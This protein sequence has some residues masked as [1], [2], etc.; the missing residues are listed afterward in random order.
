MISASPIRV[1]AALSGALRAAS[2]GL[3]PLLV[4]AVIVAALSWLAAHLARQHPLHDLPGRYSLVAI[5]AAAA[6]GW[7]SA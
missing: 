7:M 4:G 2:R 1:R 5:P 6:A 3:A